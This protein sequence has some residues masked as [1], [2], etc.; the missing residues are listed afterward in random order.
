MRLRRR[1]APDTRG[2]WLQAVQK[3]AKCSLLGH[4]LS[5]LVTAMTHHSLRCLDI[6]DVMMAPLV[7]LIIATSQVSAM[8]TNYSALL[9]SEQ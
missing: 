3:V 5:G 2:P 7:R 1:P 8:A 6:A 4:L 9:L